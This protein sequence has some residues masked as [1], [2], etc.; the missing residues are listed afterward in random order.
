MVK[1]LE[2]MHALSLFMTSHDDIFFNVLVF[3]SWLQV[4]IILDSK[5]VVEKEESNTTSNSM[6]RKMRVLDDKLVHYKC[7]IY[8]ENNAYYP[9]CDIIC[10]DVK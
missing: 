5:N 8:H 6:I 4:V 1:P 10:I 9:T 3:H 7:A 2:L